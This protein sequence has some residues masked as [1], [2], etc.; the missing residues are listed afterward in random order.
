MS[1]HPTPHPSWCDSGQCDVDNALEGFGA[2][3]SAPLLLNIGFQVLADAASVRL[4]LHQSGANWP[5]YVYVTIEADRARATL[6]LAEARR[7]LR[8]VG[9]LL[10]SA[11]GAG[12]EWR[13][14][15]ALLET[16]GERGYVVAG[17][18]ADFD[19]AADMVHA[20]AADLVFATVEAFIP[21]GVDVPWDVVRAALPVKRHQVDVAGVI[22]RLQAAGA[23]AAELRQ[24][25]LLPDNPHAPPVP[26]RQRHRDHRTRRML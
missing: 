23:G 26:P 12:A 15:T 17:L 5:T 21:A 10:A 24:L 19:A 20:G 13:Q 25:G 6:E 3:R 9:A 16:A 14:W 22:S 1:D 4:Q 2:H 11:A 8:E 18:A 7:M